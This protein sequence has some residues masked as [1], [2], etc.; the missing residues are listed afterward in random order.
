MSSR[1][2]NVPLSRATFSLLLVLCL[3]ALSAAP[4]QPRLEMHINVGGNP[5]TLE[6][7]TEFLGDGTYTPE[8]GYGHDGGG[9]SY[10][11]W[12]AIGGCADDQPYR[13]AR[14][15]LDTY[16]F[17][18]PDGTYLLTMRFSELTANGIG[19]NLMSWA[20]GPQT[21]LTDLDLVEQVDRDY[22]LDY[23]FLV[24]AE[25]GMLLL[26]VTDHTGCAKLS[27]LS[28][29]S[30]PASDLTPPATPVL[31]EAL[32]GYGEVLINWENTLDDD[33]AGY[34]LNRQPVAGGPIENRLGETNLVSKFIDKDVQPGI[35]Y[36]YWLQSIDVYGNRSPQ[37]A[38]FEVTPYD[39]IGS[40]L[41]TYHIEIDPDS[42][43]AL[44]EDP[45]EDVYYS[46][47]VTIGG[48]SY[49][50]GVRYRGNTLRALSKKSFKIKMGDLLYQDRA[51]LNCNSEMFDPCL[52]RSNLSFNL[53]ADM[54]VPAPRIWMRALMLNNEYY[55][56]CCDTEQLDSHFLDAHNLDSGGNIYK[57]LNRL[58]VYPDTAS[59][60]LNFEKETNSSEP[61]DD[62][63]DLIGTLNNTT[64]Q[65]YYEEIVSRF[66]IE[67]FI[68]YFSTLIYISDH[69][70]IFKNF[71]LYH[72]LDDGL[73][74]I[75]P[76]DKDITWGMPFLY[77]PGIVHNRSIVD[78]TASTQNML[79][80]R[81]IKEPVICNA[82]LSRLHEMI[83]ERFPIEDT[84]ER[85]DTAHLLV[86]NNGEVDWRKWHWESNVRFR[87]GA[88]EIKQYLADR[89]PFIH[90]R[91]DME[92]TPQELYINEFMADNDTALSDEFGEF[93]DWIEIY[94]PG[95]AAINLSDYFLTDDLL[96]PM[97]WAFPDTLI[98]AAGYLIVWADNDLLQGPLHANFKLSS[99][100]ETIALHK[101]S[102]GIDGDIF[103][104]V[105]LVFF[106]NQ[107]GDQ[108][109]YRIENGDLRW[110]TTSEPSPGQNNNPLSSVAFDPIAAQL[111][112][113]LVSPNPARSGVTLRF[114]TGAHLSRK[115]GTVEIYQ[116]DGRL[117]RRLKNQTGPVWHWDGKMHDGT[118]AAP[119]CYWARY[120]GED[121]NVITSERI[122]LIR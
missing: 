117:S 113:L 12:H 45:Y 88:D 49:E 65:V 51:R 37:S 100:G 116:L 26:E 58:A 108:S 118:T 84:N 54:D 21:L 10:Y 25:S 93:D 94:N 2:A 39:F 31:I 62:L 64:D 46:C 119:G 105:D 74:R 87:Q 91:L 81:M 8:R 97:Q 30:A 82:Y 11:F 9:W 13:R 63:F 68:N 83:T 7:G 80:H 99:A 96:E 15:C 103:D 59:Y 61:W 89:M 4:Q 121:N 20:I 60:Y 73:W 76:W 85:I 22:A 57:C 44:N 50:A 120:R 35:A 38:P 43:A 36:R 27:G 101:L 115:S 77:E 33:L 29:L 5:V 14:Y 1:M 28:L 71:Y 23:R 98:Q 95:P 34:I 55:G 90:S 3:S 86:A 114:A 32:P 19:Q 111:P 53:F 48:V 17:D 42:L 24:T 78:G 122:L 67:E 70:A 75:L 104:P 16:R 69:D 109:R 79:Y 112:R 41:P 72:D 92:F 107:S 6:D 106:G 110:S 18:V 66:D 52:M 102:S 47:V 56:V 40:P